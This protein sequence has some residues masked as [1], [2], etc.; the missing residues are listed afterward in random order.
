[1][2]TPVPQAAITTPGLPAVVMDGDL[3]TIQWS[4]ELRTVAVCCNTPVTLRDLTA[5]ERE[6]MAAREFQH[7]MEAAQD[8]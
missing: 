5:D 6:K 4:G 3:L 7:C 8:V 2:T 1:L